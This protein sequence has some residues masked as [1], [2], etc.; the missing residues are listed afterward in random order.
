[1]VIKRHEGGRVPGSQVLFRL[2]RFEKPKPTHGRIP[3]TGGGCCGEVAP[4]CVR[5]VQLV[6]TIGPEQSR[7]CI[8]L[9]FMKGHDLAKIPYTVP[10]AVGPSGKR[11][12]RT[13]CG[14]QPYLATVSPTDDVA[15]SSKLRKQ[16]MN[17][18]RTTPP[19]GG[20]WGA[21]GVGRTMETL[22]KSLFCAEIE[23]LGSTDLKAIA[24]AN[25]SLRR[26]SPNPQAGKRGRTF[27]C[28]SRGAAS[29]Q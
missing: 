4:G 20:L 15:R 25:G 1:V 8:R 24:S 12:P 2:L 3:E 7:I 21:G 26:N 13:T 27:R 22:W 5:P 16:A 9:R 23:E 29:S 17:D 19:G 18:A 14:R 28:R 11:R 10:A 6:R